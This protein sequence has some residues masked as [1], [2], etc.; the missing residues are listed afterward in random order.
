MTLAQIDLTQDEPQSERCYGTAYGI[1][2]PWPD[3]ADPDRE[4]DHRSIQRYGADTRN[5]NN[6]H[7]APL[8]CRKHPAYCLLM[9]CG[10]SAQQHMVASKVAGHD[11]ELEV[12]DAA[13]ARL[14]PTHGHPVA[15]MPAS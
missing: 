8:V 15:S 6:W 1:T 13:A 4:Q 3:V 10:R 2:T 7:F 5:P 12:D 14:Q 9:R 11:I